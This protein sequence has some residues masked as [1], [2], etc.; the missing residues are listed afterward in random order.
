MVEKIDPGIYKVGVT[1]D[2]ELI[3][4]AKGNAINENE[5]RFSDFMGVK[6]SKWFVFKSEELNVSLGGP[7][8]TDSRI[9]N[10]VSLESEHN[11]KSEAVDRAEYWY[12]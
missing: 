6:S 11:T 8:C 9:H 10:H 3:G 1:E 5:W 12:L 2:N 7:S 4:V